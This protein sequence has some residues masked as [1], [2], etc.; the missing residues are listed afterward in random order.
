[1]FGIENNKKSADQYLSEEDYKIK[2]LKYKNKY[3]EL[4]QSGGV[5]SP[6]GV[7]CFFT[8]NQKATEIVELFKTGKTPNFDKLSEIMHNDGYHI[9]DGSDVLELIVKPKKI[10]SF[11]SKKSEEPKEELKQNKVKLPKTKVF[12]RCDMNHVQDVKGVLGAYN[13]K[14]EAMI[15]ILLKSVGSDVLITERPIRV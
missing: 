14:P 12:N 6:T 2:Y 4:K 11:F 7:V 8:S 10:A 15:V 13:F 9:A 5:G 3:V 1:M